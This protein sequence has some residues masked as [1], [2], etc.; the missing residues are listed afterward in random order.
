MIHMNYFTRQIITKLET[1]V[2]LV[3]LCKDNSVSKGKNHT[4]KWNT[5]MKQDDNNDTSSDQK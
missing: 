2:D 5:D 1:K 3:S 4:N